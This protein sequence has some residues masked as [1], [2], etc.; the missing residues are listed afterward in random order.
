MAVERCLKHW[1]ARS[2]NHLVAF[3]VLQ[4]HNPVRVRAAFVNFKYPERIMGVFFSDR[5]KLRRR[6]IFD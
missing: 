2:E 6:I 3:E 1:A 4:N 5:I